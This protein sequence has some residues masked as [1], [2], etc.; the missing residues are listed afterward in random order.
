M[1]DF[2]LVLDLLELVDSVLKLASTV[3]RTRLEVVSIA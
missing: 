2:H 1:V 3:H